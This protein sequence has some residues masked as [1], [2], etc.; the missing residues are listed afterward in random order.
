MAEETRQKLEELRAY[1]YIE[2][3]SGDTLREM[4]HGLL[5]AQRARYIYLCGM[6]FEP[7]ELMEIYAAI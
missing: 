6:R 2:N 4:I 3:V 7:A 1:A 5:A